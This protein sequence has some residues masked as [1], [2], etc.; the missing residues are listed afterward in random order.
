MTSLLPAVLAI[1]MAL[2][3]RQVL[4]A[5][6]VGIWI[7]AFLL[8]DMGA[9]GIL[10]S[11]LATLPDYVVPAVA[12]SDHASILIFAMLIGGMVGIISDNG[13]TRGVV[14]LLMRFVRTRRHGEVATATMGTAV[15][16]DDYAT[17]M[18]AGNT[19]RPLTDRLRI[20]RAKLAYFIDSL[21][22][23]I[24]IIA[25]VSTWVG[26][27]VAFIAS[28]TAGMPG[29]DMAPYP[30]FLSSLPYN[31]YAFFT[32]IFVF[33]L[34]WSGRDFGPML[35]AR[36]RLYR[37]QHESAL[38][39]YGVWREAERTAVEPRH[40][41]WAHAVVPIVVLLTATIA[42]LFVTG[43]GE[44]VQAI[45]A[46][47]DSY[48]ALLWGSLLGVVAAMCMTLGQRLMKL[49]AMMESFM[50][51]MWVMFGGLI[52]LVLAWGLSEVTQQ[53]GAAE[54]LAGLFGGVIAPA[55]IPA[56]VLVLA[57][58]IAFS[59][60]SSWGTMGILMPL[61]LP[62]VWTLGLELNLPAVA[63][64]TM[65]LT[66]VGAV[67]AGAVFGDHA[68]PISDTTILSSLAAQCDHVEH[69]NTQLV[70]ALV[71]LALSFVALLAVSLIGV[72][73]WLVY[74][75]GTA[76]MIALVYGVG[77]DPSPDPVRPDSAAEPDSEPDAAA[78]A[79]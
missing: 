27:M 7:G 65:V 14:H 63:L 49:D 76:S 41:H 34:A 23:P 33:V 54:Y 2:V 68:S 11:L 44:S 32:L 45:I 50:R 57:A 73:W 59:T 37:A 4:I 17:I 13:G 77:S 28:G 1:V 36:L 71:P 42:G 48:T 55:W 51:G 78:S 38:D 3:F 12:D 67:L 43:D 35:K 6:F 30:L 19:M 74:V 61:A 22:S 64:N 25:L 15:F 75:L 52:I 72:P 40:A 79:P 18:V 21:A 58:A 31:F 69:V 9:A 39:T 29:F 16:F 26:A 70:Y 62:L 5:L 47:A 24:A 8:G 56:L 10:T 66:T 20:P 53:L 60:G 46:D